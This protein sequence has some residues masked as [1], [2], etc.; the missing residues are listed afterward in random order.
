MF[1]LKRQLRK[2]RRES[3]PSDAFKDALFQRIVGAPEVIPGIR[4]KYPVLNWAAVG[5]VVVVLVFGMGTGVYAYESPDVVDGHPLYFVKQKMEDVEG[6]FA[7][8]SEARAHFH[9]K[10]M[11]RRMSEA[12]R[13]ME[14]QEKLEAVLES[15]TDEL[16]LSVQ[17]LKMELR[18]HPRRKAIIERLN[19]QNDRYENA[20]KR[21]PVREGMMRPLLPPEAIRERLDSLNP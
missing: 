9:A 2:L 18:D 3:T 11:E 20:F 6:R 5:M 14:S 7:N 17:E 4:G 13:I 16:D 1:W 21:V 19:A 12:E 8:T 10:M 15:A